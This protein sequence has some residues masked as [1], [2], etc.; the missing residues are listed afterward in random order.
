[1]IKSIEFILRRIPFH[2]LA[3]GPYSV[4]ALYLFNFEQLPLFAITLAVKFVVVITLVL[5]LSTCLTLAAAKSI[6]SWKVTARIAGWALLL[7]S[8]YFGVYNLLSGSALQTIARHRY[9]LPVWAAVFIGGMIAIL[10]PN[11]LISN[12][13][14]AAVFERAT[15]IVSLALLLFLSYG[16][17]SGLLTE[18]MGFRRVMGAHSRLLLLWILVLVGGIAFVLKYKNLTVITSGMNVAAGVLLILV[19]AQLLFAEI[20]SALELRPRTPVTTEPSHPLPGDRDVYYIVLDAYSREDVLRETLD[21]DNSGFIQQLESLGFVIPACTQT[22]YHAT[23]L[24]LTSTLNMN[25]I[26]QL[27]PHPQDVA[28]YYD[29]TPYLKESLVRNIFE[30]R[31]Y[32]TYTFKGLF[33]FVNISD[34]THYYDLFAG[35]SSNLRIETENFYFIFLQTTSMRIAIDYFE[36]N[37]R[38]AESLPPPL[39]SLFPLRNV[40]S[41]RF[42]KQYQQSVYHL[43]VLEQIP[44]MPGKKF[45]YAHLFVTHEPYVFTADGNFRW[46]PTGDVAG[47]RDQIMFINRRIVQIVEAILEKSSNPPIIILQGD[48]GWVWDERRN[49]SL[50][51]YYLPEGGNT[52]IYPEISPVN[53]FRVVLNRYFGANYDLLPDIYY[54]AS[55]EDEDMR[56][57]KRIPGSCA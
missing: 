55:F 45:V 51:A 14:D 18:G 12:L 56:N 20:S 13:R 8:L 16:H 30:E 47:Y 22:N 34:S 9:M 40:F 17:V 25:Y 52:L 41:N 37:P 27:T 24:S 38:A 5:L 4:L 57:L 1:M 44:D 49:R 3:W 35:E 42:Y 32:E 46:P 36:R 28:T 15:L 23:I 39:Q 48:H 7:G 54:Y 21:F 53:T 31:G 29:Y 43:E 33:P 6:S 2:S 10:R 26:D 50:N 19:G 11:S